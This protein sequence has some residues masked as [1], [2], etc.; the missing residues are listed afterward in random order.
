MIPRLMIPLIALAAS[1]AFAQTQDAPPSLNLSVPAAQ[2]DPE[3]TLADD[4][5]GTYYGD[6]G[7]EK[8]AGNGV[9]MSGAFSTTIGY[10]KG[11]GTGISNSAELNL[12][13][14]TDDGKTFGLHLHVSKGDA[15]PYY[16]GRNRRG[17]W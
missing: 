5:P 4:P 14:Q 16:Y 7:G 8:D 3:S 6:V 1:S 2:A 11:Y 10:A 15:L 13:K 9:Q 17:G 12:S